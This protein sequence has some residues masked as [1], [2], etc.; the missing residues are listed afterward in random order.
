MLTVVWEGVPEV[1]AQRALL[2]RLFAAACA[3]IGVPPSAEATVLLTHDDRLRALNLAYRGLDAPTDV[4][5]FGEPGAGWEDTGCK[6]ALPGGN[7]GPKQGDRSR[8]AGHNPAPSDDDGPTV[9]DCRSEIAGCRPALPEGGGE[10]LGDV[11]ISLPRAQAQAA[12]YGH[13]AERELGYLFVHGFLHLLGHT[14]A[15]ETTFA[16][17]RAREEQILTAAGLPRSAAAPTSEAAGP[18]SLRG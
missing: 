7:E 5:S 9:K 10:Y 16:D 3:V 12:A 18:A 15:A 6:P 4:L 1:P 8:V 11:A 14:H 13:S 17:M 2:E